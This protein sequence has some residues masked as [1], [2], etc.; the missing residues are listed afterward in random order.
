M[1]CKT[2]FNKTLNQQDLA[3]AR[4]GHLSCDEKPWDDDKADWA[5]RILMTE[6][7]HGRWTRF[8]ELILD[9]DDKRRDEI[10]LRNWKKVYMSLFPGCDVPSPCESSTGPFPLSFM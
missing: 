10:P 2:G 8:R 1:R 3:K 6:E 7:Q 5:K 4:E 9:P